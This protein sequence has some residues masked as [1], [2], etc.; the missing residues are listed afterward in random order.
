M[1]IYEAVARMHTAVDGVEALFEGYGL[2]ISRE[3]FYSDEQLLDTSPERAKF[4]NVTLILSVSRS[5]GSGERAEHRIGIGAEAKR[6]EVS[7]AAFSEAEAEFSKRVKEALDMLR[8]DDDTLAAIA[9]L[10]R[11]AAEEYEKIAKEYERALPKRIA[12]IVICLVVAVAL[13]VIA[14]LS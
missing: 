8:E 4:V 14:T 3:E 13:I 6:G 2:S 10:D 11:R 12:A 9:E 1:K 5:D 7:E